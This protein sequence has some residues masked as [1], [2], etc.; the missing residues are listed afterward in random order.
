MIH[1]GQILID[2]VNVF[3]WLR[4]LDKQQRRSKKAAMKK[5]GE[6]TP[7]EGTG[8]DVMNGSA[9]DHNAAPSPIWIHCLIGEEIKEGEEDEERVQVRLKP[10]YNL[11]YLSIFPERS[12]K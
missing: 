2:N 6:D 11:I 4:N 12:G 9:F 8:K 10:H 5:S 1:S 7:G 3:E